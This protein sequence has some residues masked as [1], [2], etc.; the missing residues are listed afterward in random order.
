[1]YS[2]LPKSFS[3]CLVTYKIAV[4][5]FFFVSINILSA[6]NS[7]WQ[8][9]V[10]NENVQ[11]IKTVGEN[12]WIA[13]TGGLIVLDAQLQEIVRYTALNSDLPC[14]WIDELEVD[15]NG[16]VWM[17]HCYG[18]SSFDGVDFVQYELGGSKLRLDKDGNV[19]GIVTN[20]FYQWNGSGFDFQLVDEMSTGLSLGDVLMT[21]Q[22]VVWSA[23]STFGIFQLYRYADGQLEIFDYQN[24]D[25]PFEFPAEVK[26]LHKENSNVIFVL[27]KS[28]FQYQ[29]GVVVYSGDLDAF[30]DDICYND[31]G[32][33]SAIETKIEDG[34]RSIYLSHFNGD[35]SLISRDAL[36]IDT[37]REGVLSINGD[38]SLVGFS[39]V[40]LYSV[41]NMITDKVDLTQTVMSSSKINSMEI[42]NNAL[43]FTLGST[44]NANAS[45]I[46]YQD[47]LWSSKALD[48][49]FDQSEELVF[50]H[51]FEL[52]KEDTTYMIHDRLSYYQTGNGNWFPVSNPDLVQ[53]VDENYSSTF[54]DNNGDKWLLELYTSDIYYDSP[55]GWVIYPHEVHGARS[56]AYFSKFNHPLTGDLWLSTY[57]G[58]SIY[59]YDSAT[60]RV[61]TDTEM[62]IRNSPATMISTASGEVYGIAGKEFFKVEGTT[63][64]ILQSADTLGNNINY[65]FNEIYEDRNGILWL[66]LNGEVANYHDGVWNLFTKDNSGIVN[67]DITDIYQDQDSN[68]WFSSRSG[69][70]AIYNETG[71]ADHFFDTL[72]T[73]VQNIDYSN[74]LILYPNPTT[75][76]IHIKENGS[77]TDAISQIRVID[78]YGRQ[79]MSCKANKD[80][81]LNIST[82]L[83]GI[84]ILRIESEAGLRMAKVIKQ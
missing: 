71:L 82:L 65:R 64:E 15:G 32:T 77:G 30:I 10:S 2:S 14:N 72:H 18:V 57:N 76:L 73:S 27:G 26:I 31:D 50:P 24:S 36:S 80:N 54:I 16:T 62:N 84:Y 55:D 67:G 12:T 7:K 9:C 40:G 53:D 75:G 51:M 3:N 33:L 63:A 20:G 49:P 70:I 60:W 66:G 8:N 48:F 43:W 42:V 17:R 68:L 83:D 58:V 39:N 11:A 19:F 5:F 78:Q 74:L 4:L 44:Y 69:G 1:M 81:T 47:N 22:G 35:F 29:E 61:L 79:V 21:D 23:R 37:G 41:G 6:Q 45:I 34:I 56:G 38:H 52:G 59:D 13:T 28:I 25:L 46:A